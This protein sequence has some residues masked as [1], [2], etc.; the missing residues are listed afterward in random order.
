MHLTSTPASLQLRHWS[1]F[2]HLQIVLPFM[3]FSWH[4]RKTTL[5]TKALVSNWLFCEYI[6]FVFAV[7]FSISFYFILYVQSHKELGHW[8]KILLN[9]VSRSFIFF[10]SFISLFKPVHSGTFLWV[11]FSYACNNSLISQFAVSTANGIWVGMKCFFHL[12]I[13]VRPE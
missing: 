1:R 12:N 8:M 10:R 13:V 7:Y 5:S 9:A 3:D 6:Q 2:S 4:W 11:T